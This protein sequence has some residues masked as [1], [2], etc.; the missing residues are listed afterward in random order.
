MQ[1]L[2]EL[3]EGLIE[4]GSRPALG[5]SL[6]GLL[7]MVMVV[8]MSL[9]SLCG[10]LLRI[11]LDG[12][13]VGLRARKI[14]GLQILR[15]LTKRLGNRTGAR[16]RSRSRTRGRG[17]KWRTGRGVLLQRGKITLRL[18]EVPGQQVLSELL[19]LLLKLLCF[20]LRGCRLESLQKNC[21]RKC[22]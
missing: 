3:T 12:R 2:A 13:E 5:R 9:R 1:G 22:R 21:Y 18:R 17:R 8:V 7:D 16:T 14:A 19:K 6:R 4:G 11:L 10:V 15:E 20:G